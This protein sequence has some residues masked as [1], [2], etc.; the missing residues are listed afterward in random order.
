M[1]DG[2]II[3]DERRPIFNYFYLKIDSSFDS[4]Y[5]LYACTMLIK[6]IGEIFF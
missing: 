1:S 3:S 4:L 5:I 6:A 2:V